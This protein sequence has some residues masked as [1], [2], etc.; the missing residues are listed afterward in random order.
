[1][2]R[3]SLPFFL[4]AALAVTRCGAADVRIDFVPVFHSNPANFDSLAHVSDTQ[5]RLS[6][7][8]LDFLLS[9]ISVKSAAGEWL[10]LKDWSAYLSLRE[11][12]TGFTLKGLPDGNYTAIKFNVGLPPVTNKADATKF[13]AGHPLN[14]AVTTLW[15]GWTG[16]YVFLAIEGAWRR[17]DGSMS[18][19]S[20]HVATDKH[21]ME[22]EL[23]CDLKAE[24]PRAMK[25]EVDAGVILS[26][27]T[28]KDDESSTHSRGDDP[29]AELLDRNI[30]RAFR[31]STSNAETH[32]TSSDDR[33][34]ALALP[35]GETPYKF[36]FSSAFPIPQLPRDN[37]LT[38]E[39]VALGQKLFH[40]KR[41][42]INNTQS[43][44]DCHDATHAFTD[45]RKF[46]IGAEGGIGTRNAMPLFNLAWKQSYFWDGRAPTLRDQVLQ[47]IQNP[48]EMH[49]TLEG[50][51]KKL[52]LSR[53]KI[54]RSLEQYALTLIAPEAR[55]DRVMRHEEAFTPE[56]QRGF[57]LFHTEYDPRREQF[58]ADCF[59]CHGGPLFQSMAFAN[60]GLDAAPPD[61][62]RFETTKKDGDKGKFAVPSL[63]NIALTGPYMHDG[64]FATLEEV[65]EHYSTGVH[66]SDTLD[67][68]LAKHPEKGL[69]LGTADKAALVAFLKTLTSEPK[70]AP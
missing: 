21:L 47:P 55:F 38:N 9:E 26:G 30:R 10:A 52:G 27:V 64:R 4:L 16:G 62:G 53:D 5:Q 60:N 34:P 58:G 22:V 6:I 44:A 11:S 14:P 50:V 17:T 45:P 59:H 41:L 12:R 69:N 37:P 35:A 25:I 46:S 1:M 24:R 31:I 49:E 36:T 70:S 68:N 2:K 63:R 19:Y 23:P 56:E 7:T 51:E 18:G 61:L 67:P 40:D 54:A 57:E 66:R 15:W 8:R 48:I 33:A 13:P 43:C 39:G 20:F 3:K 28:F 29:L 65:I 32:T 42:S